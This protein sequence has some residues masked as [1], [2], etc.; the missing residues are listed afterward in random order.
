MNNTTENQNTVLTLD[1]SRVIA[2][3]VEQVFNAWLDPE[4]LAKFMIPAA[5]M[6]R[7]KVSTEAQEGG[8]F[9]IIMQVGDQQ[10]P[11]GGKYLK[12][13]PYQ[14]IVFTWESAH[15][16][17]GSQ[18]TLN[19]NSEGDSTLLTLSQVKFYDE[20]AKAAHEGG[21]ESILS[22]LAQV[23]LPDAIASH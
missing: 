21:W 23:L 2:R 18:V 16:I 11:H 15:S 7:P 5:G 19:F 12:I 13:D 14:C 17:E 8:Q 10:L 6:Q 22:H 1:I 3:P 20:A 4:M 9:S